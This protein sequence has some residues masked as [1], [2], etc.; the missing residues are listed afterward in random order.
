M[1]NENET[2]HMSILSA[3]TNTIIKEITPIR[4]LGALD[5]LNI[6]CSTDILIYIIEVIKMW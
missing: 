6:E 2:T 3:G 5:F 4:F 1:V